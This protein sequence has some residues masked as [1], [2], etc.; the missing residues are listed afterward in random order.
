M[1]MPQVRYRGPNR[2][3]RRDHPISAN[4]STE[5]VE[6]NVTVIEEVD[7]TAPQNVTDVRMAPINKMIMTIKRAPAPTVPPSDETWQGYE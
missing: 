1:K 7:L 4:T 5:S 2:S 6:Q 3:Q